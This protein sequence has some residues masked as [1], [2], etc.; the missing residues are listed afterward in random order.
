MFTQAVSHLYAYCF[1]LLSGYVHASCIT[2]LCLLFHLLSGHVH[3][4]CITSQCLLFHLLSGHVHASCTTSL[5]PL[6]CHSGGCVQT[7]DASPVGPDTRDWCHVWHVPLWRLSANHDPQW[8]LVHHIWT[9]EHHW[10]NTGKLWDAFV[11]GDLIDFDDLSKAMLVQSSDLPMQLS[12]IGEFV[13]TLVL[14]NGWCPRWNVYICICGEFC[15][16]NHCKLKV[17]TKS[18]KSAENATN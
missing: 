10:V 14:W 9:R 7:S 15:L 12:I 6:L 16:Q 4:S 2:S 11:T 5:H 13:V 17:C 18:V 8:G 1:C 3:T